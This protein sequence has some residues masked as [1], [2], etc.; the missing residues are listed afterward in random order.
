MEFAPDRS[1]GYSTYGYSFASRT[2]EAASGQEFLPLMEKTTFSL[3]SMN[4]TGVDVSPDSAASRARDYLA[5]LGFGIAP[6]PE[7][8]LSWRWAGGGYR[9]TP[10]DLAR[11]ADAVFA[12]AVLD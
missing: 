4:G 10:G 3:L 5:I 8:S 9:L 2:M 1:F 7:K 6:A 12:G 11:F